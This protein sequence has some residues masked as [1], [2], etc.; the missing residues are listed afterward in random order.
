M[1]NVQTIVI[2]VVSWR[3]VIL[4]PLAAPRY[5]TEEKGVIYLY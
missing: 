2:K 4:M 3:L 5:L 1:P